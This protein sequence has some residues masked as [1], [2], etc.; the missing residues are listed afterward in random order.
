MAER[1][2]QEAG[3]RGQRRKKR[4]EEGKGGEGRKDDR[5][6]AA[7]CDARSLFVGLVG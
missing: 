7:V 5:R 2:D 6:M 1:G 3:R 4:K